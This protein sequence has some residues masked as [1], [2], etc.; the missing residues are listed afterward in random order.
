MRENS[1]ERVSAHRAQYNRRDFR[2]NLF[3]IFV[4]NLNPVVDLVGLWGMLKPFG[5]VRDIFLLPKTR[6]HASVYASVR[7]TTMY[8]AKQMAE[9]IH[10]RRSESAK[11]RKINNLVGEGGYGKASYNHHKANPLRDSTYAQVVKGDSMNGAYKRHVQDEESNGKGP[12]KVVSIHW[13]SS[14][15]TGEWLDKCVVGELTEF[16][17]VIQVFNR[18]QNRGIAFSPYYLGNKTILWAFESFSEAETFARSRFLWDDCF[19]SVNSWSM[20]N[21]TFTRLAWFDFTWVPLNCWCK[22]FFK[23]IGGSFGEVVPVEE[24]TLLRKRLDRGRVL[25]IMP[26]EKASRES[27]HVKED[28]FFFHGDNV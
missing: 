27:V 21:N 13:K 18:L 23:T 24:E 28:R 16:K 7:F 25:I 22:E 9:R 19:N 20:E 4:D 6:I 17:S 11:R 8:E 15:I 14:Q 26:Q 5:M 2:E 1:R 12:T 3:S 10:D